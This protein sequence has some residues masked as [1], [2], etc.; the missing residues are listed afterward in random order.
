L[1]AQ[2]RLQEAIRTYEQSLQLASTVGREAQRFTAP[3]HLGLAMLS[4]ELGNDNQALQHF[5]T[6]LELGLRCTLTDWP[7]HKY[8]TQARWKEYEGD[9]HAAL[10]LLDEARRV[11]IQTLIPDAYPAEAW[12]VRVYLKQ[13]RLSKAQ[14]WARE[15]GLAVDDELSYL[16]E[17]EHLTLARVM[18]AEYQGSQAE[19]RI[20][21]ALR[22]LE[23][24]LKAA[25]EGKRT[26]ST[27]ETLILQALA[28]QTRGNNPQAFASLKRALTL[29]EPEGYLRI[30]VDEGKAMVEL[31]SRLSQSH[32]SG[33]PGLSEVEGSKEYIRRLLSAFEKPSDDRDAAPV[34]PLIDP[35]SKRE[36]EVL[37]LVAQGFSNDQISKRLF[38]SVSTVKGHNLRIFG[39]L[40]VKSRTEAVARARELGLL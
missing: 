2:G 12:K 33:R 22:L 39:K 18:I 35:L 38:L 32:E 30:F 4:L 17:F 14:D 3:H 5:Q 28:H 11:Y 15:H 37:R 6:G 9:F 26:G 27:I 16:H 31:L 7:Y 29:A 21:D 24:L 25:E 36:L 19:A 40:Q 10:E 23:R 1:I 8:V 34:Q 13:G 20:R